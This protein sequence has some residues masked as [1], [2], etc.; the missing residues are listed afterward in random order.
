M[1]PFL[2]VMT[3]RCH[4]YYTCLAPVAAG[5][6]AMQAG[7]QTALGSVFD[8]VELLLHV[9]DRLPTDRDICNLRAVNRS[10]RTRVCQDTAKRIRNGSYP[11]VHCRV[12]YS[13][14]R[15]AGHIV[16]MLFVTERYVPRDS[17]VK[18]L[19][20]PIQDDLLNRWLPF[21][22]E[23]FRDDD[24][25]AS[26]PYETLGCKLMIA[27]GIPEEVAVWFLNQYL[28]EILGLNRETFFFEQPT[29]TRRR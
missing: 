14:W 22:C 2:G 8:N 13:A 28:A 5:Q 23:R 15:E 3:C 1:A 12:Q 29:T 19:H 25:L 21:I 24:Q 4:E 9:V 17:L 11:H 16:A 18:R 26:M 27:P 7:R 10:M 20:V 6:E